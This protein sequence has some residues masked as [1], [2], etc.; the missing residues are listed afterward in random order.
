MLNDQH[1]TIRYLA[2]VGWQ[3]RLD[4][5]EWHTCRIEQDARFIAHGM[6]IAAGVMRGERTGEE[7]ARELDQVAASLERQVGPCGT[8]RSIVAAAEKA[9]LT[10]SGEKRASD[11]IDE[12][13]SYPVRMPGLTIKCE[14]E[15]DRQ[16]L[17]DANAIRDQSQTAPKFPLGRLQLIRDACDRYSLGTM[18]KLL[19]VEIERVDRKSRNVTTYNY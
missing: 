14:S 11:W 9:R 2:D 6:L 13:K 1:A 4:D 5:N 18:Q 17:Q 15:E 16:L 12:D 8:G 7:V 3:V 19:K 10:A